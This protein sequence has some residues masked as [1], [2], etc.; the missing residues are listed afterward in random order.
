MPV[1]HFERFTRFVVLRLVWRLLGYAVRTDRWRVINCLIQ[2][3]ELTPQFYET[4]RLP[5]TR[6]NPDYKSD[7]IQFSRKIR[8]GSG[9]GSELC[10]FIYAASDRF[11][12]IFATV[13]SVIK[14]ISTIDLLAVPFR[15]GCSN[16]VSHHA[17]PQDR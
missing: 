12:V 14:T 5:E 11:Q 13:S 8:T 3:H 1:D 9:F 2:G 17:L 4:A 15:F 16:A 10:Q 6:P 7:W